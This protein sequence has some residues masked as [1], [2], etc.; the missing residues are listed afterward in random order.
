MGIGDKFK[1]LFNGGRKGGRVVE[2]PLLEEELKGLKDLELTGTVDI[3]ELMKRSDRGE[4]L[5]DTE[6]NELTQIEDSCFRNFR[7]EM[8]K[9]KQG[10]SIRVIEEEIDEYK[11]G[12]A[13]NSEVP[14]DQVTKE[15]GIGSSYETQ[16]HGTGGIGLQ[17]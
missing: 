8:T 7:A 1:G 17:R 5:S 14:S 10:K 3:D 15:N 16:L 4:I 9:G 6:L 11:K 12:R 2:E 13:A